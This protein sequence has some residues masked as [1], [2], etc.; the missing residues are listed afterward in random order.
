MRARRR[1]F[2][3]GRSPTPALGLR[4]EARLLDGTYPDQTSLDA[5]LAGAPLEVL[6]LVL[7]PGSA[8]QASPPQ[9]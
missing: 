3:R 4:V 2:G 7:R 8:G 6:T 9:P 1:R 5:A